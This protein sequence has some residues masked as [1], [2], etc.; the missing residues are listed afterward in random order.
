MVLILSTAITD[1]A[2]GRLRIDIITLQET[3]LVENGSPKE[4]RQGITIE[5]K[6]EHGV[7]FVVKNSLFMVTGPPVN[8]SECILTIQLSTR[9][10]R[11]NI[12]SVYTSTF[13]SIAYLKDQFYEELDD[14]IGNI[15][16]TEQT[17]W[18]IVMQEW[19][20]IDQEACPT[21]WLGLISTLMQ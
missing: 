17:Y 7:G 19:V 10:G 12:T 3:R 15:P 1:S 18:E 11:V 5:E 6:R 13:C 21:I 8:G 14:A 9:A 20:P 2:L 16:K 4:Q